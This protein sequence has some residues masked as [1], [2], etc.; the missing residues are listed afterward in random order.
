MLHR[1]INAKGIEECMQELRGQ[2]NT[3][4]AIIKWAVHVCAVYCVNTRQLLG[5]IFVVFNTYL[6]VLGETVCFV[7]QKP[8]IFRSK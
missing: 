6:L 5:I 8:S 4:E 2:D 7:S 1:N 3:T